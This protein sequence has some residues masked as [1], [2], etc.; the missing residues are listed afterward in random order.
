MM[1][2]GWV[3]GSQLSQTT[4]ILLVVKGTEIEVSCELQ[5]YV[6]IKGH[7]TAATFLISPSLSE[8]I[9]AIGW[10]TDNKATWN[11][12]E[13]TLVL[14]HQRI[15]FRAMPLIPEFGPF[16]LKYAMAR[17]QFV[18]KHVGSKVDRK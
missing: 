9:L 2:T 14:G 7:R 10:L 3:D 11:F 13:N 4:T 12:G 15:V 16:F 5:Q 18:S 6:I 8:A 1:P 17:S